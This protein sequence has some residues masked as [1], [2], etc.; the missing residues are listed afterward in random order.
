MVRPLGQ[1]L[2]TVLLVASVPVVKICNY[3]T[4]VTVGTVQESKR[5]CLSAV[6]MEAS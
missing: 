2:G 6:M 5:L 1:Q 4:R 3:C